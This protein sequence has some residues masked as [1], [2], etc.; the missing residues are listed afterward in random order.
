MN[1]LE[2]RVHFE[3]VLWLPVIVQNFMED[4]GK[5]AVDQSKKITSHQV[6]SSGAENLQDF[7]DVSSVWFPY[8]QAK[9]RSDQGVPD[10]Q[11]SREANADNRSVQLRPL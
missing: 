1:D 3:V 6:L 11:S 10:A 9:L 4:A 7:Y 2:R 5:L 8:R